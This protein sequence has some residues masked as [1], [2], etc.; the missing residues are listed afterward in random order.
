MKT[1]HSIFVPSELM[2][3]SA[4][5]TNEFIKAARTINQHKEW[6]CPVAV[7]QTTVVKVSGV[8]FVFEFSPETDFDSIIKFLEMN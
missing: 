4:D 7:E 6:K 5:E 3:N 1:E 8:E 2:V